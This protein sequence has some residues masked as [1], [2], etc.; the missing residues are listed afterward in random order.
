M[1]LWTAIDAAAATKGRATGPF[2]ADGVSIDSRTVAKG[3]LFVALK[4]P[5]FDGHD[6]VADALAKG[7]AAAVVA[8]RPAGCEDA[9]LL[10]V[11]DTDTALSNLARAARRRTRAKIAAVTGSVGKTGTKE[12]LA[13]ALSDQGK[14]A[15]SP[16]NLNNQWGLP[17]SLARLPAD[18]AF[19]V[20]ELGM[21][22]AGEIAQLT[23]LAQPDVAIITTIAPVHLEYFNST[24]EIAEAKAEIF[25][26]MSGGTAVLNRD[27]AYFPLLA[28]HATGRGVGRVFGFGAHPDANARLEACAVDSD[29][30]SVD[31]SLDGKELHYRLGL[32]GRQWALSSLAVLAATAALGAD[33]ATAMDALTR[34]EGLDGR[35]RRHKVSLPSGTITLIDES[36]NASPVSMR[37][38]IDVLAASTPGTGGRRIAVLGDMLE[39]GPSSAAMHAALAEALTANRIDLVFLVG[40]QMA[41]LESELPRA[42]RGGRS[43]TADEAVAPIIAQLRDGDVVTV[44]A[45]H[46]IRTDRIVRAI[47]DAGRATPSRH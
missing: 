21:N 30:T 10:I 9:P 37:A 45:S 20:F 41:A 47:L 27:N 15:H 13:K 14:T 25:E 43:K 39:L 8:H 4:G 28:G 33:V 19:G 34:M 1:T 42:M 44:K 23:R 38:A 7:A 35:G 18:A 26:G 16:G 2:A 5:S 31:A 32:P 40:K 3:D 6:Y 29:G 17:L 12:A 22:H 24:F 36:Y 46:G 11:E